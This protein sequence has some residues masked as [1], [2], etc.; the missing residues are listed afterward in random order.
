MSTRV[1]LFE[2]CLASSWYYDAIISYLWK[3]SSVHFFLHR[4]KSLSRTVNNSYA[5]E[6]KIRRCAECVYR[7]S[8][9]TRPRK[10]IKSRVQKTGR[11]YFSLRAKSRARSFLRDRVVHKFS[12]RRPGIRPFAKMKC[13]RREMD[14]GRTIPGKGEGRNRRFWRWERKRGR[15]EGAC[16]QPIVKLLTAKVIRATM[17]ADIRLCVASRKTVRPTRAAKMKFF[18]DTKARS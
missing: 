10:V 2:F 14:D 8:Y 11:T 12:R 15:E 5:V 17:P 3:K 7:P 6:K 1:S 13:T 18:Y 16:D 4:R 9:P